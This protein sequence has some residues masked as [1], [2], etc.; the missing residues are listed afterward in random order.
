VES[1]WVHSALL[2]PMAHCVSLGWLWWWINWW[3]DWQGKPKY[4]EQTCPSAALSTTNTT[5]CPDANPGRRGGKPA[6]NRL[7]YGTALLDVTVV[8]KYF[9]AVRV[10]C[11]LLIQ[12]RRD[13]SLK[14]I[15]V[16]FFVV[17]APNLT[18]FLP[19]YSDHWF[20]KFKKWIIFSSIFWD[21]TLYSPVMVNRRFGGTYVL[22]LQ[23]RS[24]TKNQKALLAACFMLVSCL[25]QY[26]NRYFPPNCR[27]TS[28]WLCSV[29]CQE[30][31]PFITTAV[32]TSSPTKKHIANVGTGTRS[33]DCQ[34]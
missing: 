1:N 29:M 17:R 26:S 2:P 33:G 23:G 13:W 20:V 4:S 6:T 22:D 19:P 16:I 15:V 32:R 24:Q 30:I 25:A 34:Q 28:I 31:E 3:N 8:L 12:L 14:K 18:V 10:K 21:I 5:C 27:L 9:R 7:I 11:R